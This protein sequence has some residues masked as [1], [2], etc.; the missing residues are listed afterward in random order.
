MSRPTTVHATCQQVG[1]NRQV[2]ATSRGYCKNHTPPAHINL[3]ALPDWFTSMDP[4]ER[5]QITAPHRAAPIRR[6]GE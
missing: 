4:A 2:K 3:G 5:Y 1:C 6:A